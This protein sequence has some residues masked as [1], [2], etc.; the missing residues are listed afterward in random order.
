ME[1]LWGYLLAV[2]AAALAVMGYDKGQARRRGRRVAEKRLLAL[3]AI[4][5]AVGIWLGMRIFRHK[6]KHLSFVYAVPA[7]FLI[8]AFLI[9]YLTRLFPS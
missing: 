3:A 9:Y 2:N 7:M 1:L 5:G 8:Q 4:G 6:T